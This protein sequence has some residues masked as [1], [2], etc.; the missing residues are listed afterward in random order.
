MGECLHCPVLAVQDLVLQVAE[1]FNTEEVYLFSEVGFRK[2]RFLL[3]FICVETAVPRE[4]VESMLRAA[5]QQAEV[6]FFELYLG[7]KL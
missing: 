6:G 1:V 4:G 3:P 5:R 2:E 7:H